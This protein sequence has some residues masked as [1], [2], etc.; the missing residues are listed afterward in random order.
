M[1]VADN[2]GVQSQ[3]GFLSTAEGDITYCDYRQL[4]INTNTGNN[5]YFVSAPLICNTLTGI[6]KMIPAFLMPQNR[7]QLTINS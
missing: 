6:E 1:S 7:Q 4:T 2:Q 5:S 3:Y